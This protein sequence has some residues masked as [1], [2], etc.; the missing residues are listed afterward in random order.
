[1]NWTKH[2]KDR[3][4]ASVRM[5]VILLVPRFFF[6]DQLHSYQMFK[7]DRVLQTKFSP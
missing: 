7:E 5:V 4:Q 2:V 6:L 3:D 1:V